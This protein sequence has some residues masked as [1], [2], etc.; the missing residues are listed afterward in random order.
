MINSPQSKSPYIIGKTSTKKNDLDLNKTLKGVLINNHIKN[1]E[2]FSFD[3]IKDTL[4]ISN[5][6]SYYDKIPIENNGQNIKES[7][8]D[9]KK[10]LKPL[11]AGTALL[12]AGCLGL[13]S[14]FKSAS[15]TLLNSKSYEQL[16]DLAINNNIKQ[17]PQFAI[18]RV[19]RDPNF[20]NILGAAAV[21][22]MSGITVAAKNFVDGTKDIWMKKK[23]AD[24]EKELQENLISVE[25]EAFSGKLK[26]VNDM[27]SQNVEYFDK[28]LN[29]PKVQKSNIFS[30]ITSFK[31]ENKNIL[32][33][34]KD[35]KKDNIKNLKYLLL[36]SAVTGTA[37]IAGKISIS[38][39]KAAAKN[40]NK[41]AN[42]IALNTVDLI[43]KKATNPINDDLPDVIRYLK[44]ICA[45]PE[46]I[47][48]IGKKYNLSSDK[49]NSIINSVEEEKRRIFADA[50][51]ALGGIPQKLQYYCY[52]DENRGHLYNWILHP[53]NKFTKYIF[54]SFT[55]S[56]AIGYVFNK[57]MEA[58]KDYTVMKENAKTELDLRK[59][60]VDVEIQ[61][62][63][64]KKE[65]AVNPLVEDFTRQANLGT[66]SKEELKQLAD[67]ILFETKN[68]PPYVYT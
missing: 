7:S 31:G 67:N 32:L 40:T 9:E 42:N 4:L 37:L 36:A 24:I 26:I 48:E 51:S 20:S 60:L 27:L 61:N 13:S 41:L 2:K 44:S 63:K 47:K 29:K 43:N 12:L 46:Y 34:D 49:I 45:K 21:F 19:I 8:F 52:L 38:N 55:L 57:S 16:P 59:R 10:A 28:I 58:L 23:S 22:V 25:T 17:E 35:K 30:S 5:S 68:G 62:F 50:P 65:S 1:D 18:Y 6:K 14:V 39:L 11:L 54:L 64:S 53:D 56:S 66:K 33:Q 3:N 15:K